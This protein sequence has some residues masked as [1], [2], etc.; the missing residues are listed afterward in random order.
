MGFIFEDDEDMQRQ[1]F[2]AVEIQADLMSPFGSV[3]LVR[4]PTLENLIKTIYLP[5][6]AATGYYWASK[7]STMHN[8][9][10]SRVLTAI[11]VENLRIVGQV[12]ARASMAAARKLPGAFA[13][14]A[15]YGIG[16]G[17]QSAYYSL[18]GM[19]IGDIR[20]SR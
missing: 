18:S 15:L 9:L 11:R 3:E 19:H 17:L 10:S 12:A 14:A 8:P 5:A 16:H 1:F 13:L 4:E 7:L 2:D 20:F 6:T